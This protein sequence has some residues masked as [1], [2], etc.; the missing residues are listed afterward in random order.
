[1]TPL[2]GTCSGAINGVMTPDGALTLYRP[3]RAGIQR[4][5]KTAVRVCSDA[6]VKRAAKQLGG[7]SRG[8]IEVPSETALDIYFGPSPLRT[9]SARHASL[10]PLPW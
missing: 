5:L 3:M 6:D 8:R 4:V 9:S 10:R 7:W 2:R 1:M